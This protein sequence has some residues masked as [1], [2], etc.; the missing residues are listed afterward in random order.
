ARL[1]HADGRLFIEVPN[2]RSLRARLA[3]PLLSRAGWFD[4]RYRAFPIHL[5]YFTASSL[6]RALEQQ[7]F[8]VEAEF[9]S[10]MGVEELIRRDVH[11][12]HRA[13]PEKS[14]T[15]SPSTPRRRGPLKSAI[16]G[17][18]LD[19]ALGESLCIVARAHRGHRA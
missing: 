4:E 17:A 1:L 16:R 7:G 11:V 10:G 5:W 12:P 14:P 3:L 18:I 9:T 2:A 8:S 19:S 13:E 6:R 15:T